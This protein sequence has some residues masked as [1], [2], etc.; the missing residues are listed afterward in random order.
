MEMTSKHN[1]AQEGFAIFQTGFFYVH[2]AFIAN[3]LGGS[4]T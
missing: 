3:H 1:E 4:F 2:V